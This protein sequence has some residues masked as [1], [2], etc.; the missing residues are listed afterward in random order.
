[1]KRTRLSFREG[2]TQ[3]QFVGTLRKYYPQILFTGG[4]AGERLSM[5]QAVRR[6]RSGYLRGSPDIVIFKPNASFH[7]LFIE[8]K[9]ETGRQSPEQVDFARKAAQEG[10]CYVVCR[11]CQQAIDTLEKYLKN[12]FKPDL[13]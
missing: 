7:A 8:F 13:P 11:S 10:Y 9:S 4:F 5:P 1:M 2:V 6:K 12:D 3:E